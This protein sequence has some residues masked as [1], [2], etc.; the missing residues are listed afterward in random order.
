MEIQNISVKVEDEDATIVLIASL[1]PFYENL[2]T[3]F[4]VGVTSKNITM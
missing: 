1:P 3:Y 4:G 2:V